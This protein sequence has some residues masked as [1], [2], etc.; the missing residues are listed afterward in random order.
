MDGATRQ[1]K[2]GT[3]PGGRELLLLALS[4][5]WLLFVWLL[6]VGMGEEE[7]ERASGPPGDLQDRFSQQRA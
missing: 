2:R 1:A 6:L 3:P 4:L 7:E 5:L